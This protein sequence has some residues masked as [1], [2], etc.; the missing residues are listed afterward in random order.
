MFQTTR[1]FVLLLLLGSISFLSIKAQTGRDLSDLKALYAEC[2][3]EEYISFGLF[4]TA[5]KGKQKIKGLKQPDL[6]TI[7]DFSKPSTELRLFVIDLKEKQL[8]IKSLV[9]HGKNSG[10]NYAR[11]FSNQSQ[12]LKSSLGF[13]KTAE[14]Y[15]GKHGY[16]L[17]LDVLEKGIN[18]NSRKRAIVIHG[19]S[20][21]SHDFA[22]KH[23][24]LGRSWGCPALPLESTKTII[25]LI[26][27]GSCLFIYASD[28][29]YL[30][31][32]DYIPKKQ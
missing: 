29:H 12:S 22:R 15:R 17:R 27:G 9:A 32:S 23:G 4:E 5:V 24:R 7:I 28:Q 2:D 11:A 20:Y 21:V 1:L 31:H 16:S 13:Y 10:G 3:I 18:S 6:I 19:A 8:K 26:K 25:D 30:S 14:T